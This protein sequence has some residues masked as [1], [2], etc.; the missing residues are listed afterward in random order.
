MSATLA[1]RP[2]P[3]IPARA[4]PLR[5]LTIAMTV[6]CYLASLAAGSLILINRS[7]DAWT[8]DLAR[9]VTV[10]IREVEGSRKID[11]EIAKAVAVLGATEGVTS[12][13]I[14]DEQVARKLLEP[15]LGEAGDLGELPIPRLITVVVDPDN[16]PDFAALEKRLSEQVAGASLDTHRRWQSELTRMASVLTMLAYAILTLIC[17]CAVAM[18]VFATRAALEANREIVAVLH[19]VGARDRFIARQVWRRF[20]KT[21]LTAGIVGLLLGLV[22]FLA[23]VAAAPD[24]FA[25]IQR[26]F[27][28]F[29][30]DKVAINYAILAAVPAVATLISLITS[31][32]TLLRILRDLR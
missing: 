19:L 26:E 2:E 6:M 27:L 12:V 9:E 3:I 4:A 17:I 20:L 22:T 15:W 7:V 5:T 8:G 21:G 32:L 25:A 11:D 14:L 24:S 13:A 28:T 18:V 29:S 10:Q 23:A 30:T 31:R 1:H 16:P